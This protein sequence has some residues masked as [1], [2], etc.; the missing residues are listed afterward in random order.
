MYLSKLEIIGFKSFANRTTLKF[1]SGMT[2]IVGPNGCG[3]TN[4]VDAIRWALGEQK[5]S[6]LR[7]DVMENVIFNGSRNRKP[8]GMS[9]VSLT[10]ENTKGIL[11]TEY[12]EVTITRRLFRSGESEYLLNKAQCR[13]K[14]I[15]ELFMDTGMG[16]N[17]YS[18]IELKMIET[19]LSDRT[20][21]RR[22]L[23]EEAAGVTK[24]KARRK[25]AIRRLDQVT[26]DL[27]KIDS[28]IREVTKAVASLERQAEKA[29]K[30]NELSAILRTS[31]V[32]L[33][34]REYAESH[35]RVTPL[36]N[37]LREHEQ[38]RSHLMTE[39]TKFE[40]LIDLVSRE[41]AEIEEQ[42][43][44]S[45]RSLREKNETFRRLRETIVGTGERI[46]A[47]TQNHERTLADIAHLE[48]TQTLLSAQ[49]DTKR[50]SLGEL[51]SD[52]KEHARLKDEIAMEY[53]AVREA[54]EAK[55]R[56]LASAQKTVN[57]L[58]AEKNKQLEEAAQFK[59]RLEEIDRQI[60]QRTAESAHFSARERELKDRHNKLSMEHESSLR[61]LAD[62]EQERREAMT[63]RES[64]KDTIDD[65]QNQ[66]FTVQKEIGQH[67]SKIEF[68]TSLVER[69]LGTSEGAEFLMKS[70]G[71]SKSGVPIT[72]IDAV[73]TVEEYRVAV[74]NALGDSGQYFVVDT[75]T[76][77]LEA[78]ETLKH[79]QKGKATF[80]CLDEVPQIESAE[81]TATILG[82]ISFEKKFEKLYKLL[83]GRTAISG[84]IQEAY[85]LLKSTPN[86]DRVVTLDGELVARSGLLRGGSKKNSEGSLIGKQHQINELEEKVTVLRAQVD[87]VQKKIAD[88]NASYEAIKLG[89]VE[90]KL[91]TVQQ[92]FRVSE[93]AIEECAYDL[94]RSTEQIAKFS[95]ELKN[96][97]IRKAEQT[98]ALQDVAPALEELDEQYVSASAELASVQLSVHSAETAVAAETERYTAAQLSAAE[99]QNA[100]DSTV[101][102]VKR[103]EQEIASSIAQLESKRQDLGRMSSEKTTNEDK[104]SELNVMLT[105]LEEEIHS[106]ESRHTEI[107]E[108]KKEK[109]QLAQKYREGLREQRSEHEKTINAS[110]ELD[111][112]IREIEAKIA[113]LQQRSREEFEIGELLVKEFADAD[114]FNFAEA[115][116]EI[117]RLRQQIK[118]LGNVNHL[119]YEEFT[120]ERERLEF[121]TTQRKDLAEA[122]N[123]LLETIEEINTT[124]TNKF[125][126][127]FDQIRANFKDI[128]RSLFNEGDEC[129]L[130]LEEGKDPLEAQIEIT[131]QPRGKKPHG[132]ES[133]SGGEKTMTAIALLFAIYLVKP[134]PFCI[135]DE[136]D[137]PLDDANIDRFLQLI[138]KF[139]VETQFIVVTHNKRT[140]AAADALYG[141]TQEEDGV[142][143]IVSVRLKREL[144]AAA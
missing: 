1:D 131:A 122:Q 20:E 28:I 139:T 105:S 46:S 134:S 24:Y 36:R 16:A 52:A 118:N 71:W 91:Q 138:K 3:K 114:S 22:K 53:A 95:D 82:K 35:A 116:E 103:L 86:I 62:A 142:S 12:S 140:M 127:T 15:I 130:R 47:L 57:E 60:G 5:S 27:E 61:K 96:L 59:A 124:A 45:E 84:S 102:E 50:S 137:A 74:E 37:L 11:P 33:L 26:A 88:A 93:R 69:T 113:G 70:H 72:V 9:E 21:E 111:I 10:I 123:T 55:R 90:E 25:E 117:L 99:A 51:E 41:E 83:L 119:A 43:N 66:S 65:L 79:S 133:L 48:G 115:R 141:V 97:G 85:A 75:R 40:S 19:I 126:E 42:L 6:T 108:H 92:S 77:A 54:L 135:L 64:L 34:E 8:L 13:L 104:L 98:A 56:E 112:K 106:N 67:L 100:Y 125:I 32:D 18:V 29:Q 129:E 121:L 31:E 39:L 80:I 110:H 78:V 68:L 63:Q 30:Y 76:E 44:L 14:D 81:I 17:A 73:T 87:A 136:V 58:L 109:Q 144:A 2:S 143:K 101:S 128:F 38:T 132:I 107:S 120:K 7:S 4:V 94:K 49:C 23:F 89:A